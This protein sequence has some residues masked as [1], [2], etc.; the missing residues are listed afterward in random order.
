M[1]AKFKIVENEHGKFNIKKKILFFFWS[2]VCCPNA[3]R[4]IWQSNTKRGAQ[5]F[6]NIL[7]RR[8]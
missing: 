4:V 2:Y 5:A 1:A 6:I 8:R 3:P 7:N